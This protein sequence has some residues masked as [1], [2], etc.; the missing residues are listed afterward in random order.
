MSSTFVVTSDALKIVPNTVVK[1]T[2]GGKIFN[3]SDVIYYQTLI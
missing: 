2:E 3:A 1:I